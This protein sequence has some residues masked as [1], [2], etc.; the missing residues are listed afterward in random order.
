MSFRPISRITLR[1]QSVFS[2]KMSL[3]RWKRI[4]PAYQARSFPPNNFLLTG[5]PVP[6]RMGTR[7]LETPSP[8]SGTILASTVPARPPQSPVPPRSG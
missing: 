3:K 2:V 1:K 7:C 8:A 5:K 6:H 4:K